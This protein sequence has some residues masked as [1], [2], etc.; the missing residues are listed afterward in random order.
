VAHWQKG[1]TIAWADEDVAMRPM[2]YIFPDERTPATGPRLVSY[3]YTG[4]QRG[5]MREQLLKGGLRL[6]GVINRT[7][8]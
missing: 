4:A 2:L 3:G 1:D 8:E 6:A 7:F 5:R